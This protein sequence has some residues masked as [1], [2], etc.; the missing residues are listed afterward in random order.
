MPEQLTTYA[1]KRAEKAE[2]LN[3]FSGFKLLHVRK[4]IKL[5]LGQIGRGDIF[6]EYT[7]HDISHIDS[8][9]NSLEWLIPNE[10]KE[11]MSST[12]WLLIVLSVY[13]H[14]MG[15]LVTKQEYE[16][17]HNSA[18]TAF[19]NKMLTDEFN[20][21]FINK[22][23]LLEDEKKEKFLF[24]EFVRKTHAERIKY[25]IISEYNPN[26]VADVQIISELKN[27]LSNLDPMFRRDLG[28]VCES[29]HLSDLE[30]FDKYKI[31]QPYG[32]SKEEE[33]NLHYAALVL[34]TADLLN[35]TSDR[36]PTIE[37]NLISPSDPLSQEEWCKQKAV[38]SVR[39][40]KVVVESEST[41]KKEIDTIEVHAYFEKSEGFFAL[42][43]YL[44]Y[45]KDQLTKSFNLN[46]IAKLK[47]GNLFEFPW[48]KICD[49]NIETVNF[50]KRQFEFSLDQNRIL[51]LLVG[52][53]LYNDSSVVLRE[54]SQ[55][56]L[57]AVKL[58]KYI[59]DIESKQFSPKID[60]HWDENKRELSFLDNGTG[61]TLEVIENHLLK[62]GSSRYHDESFIKKYP[63]FSSISRF[64][65][66]LL[67]CFLIANDLDIITKS[68]ENEKAIKICIRKVHGKYL[69]Q[70]LTSNEIHESIKEHGTE[71][72]L[73]L[74][75]DIDLSKI[76]NELNKWIVFPNCDF[77][78]SLNDNKYTIGYK[79]PKDLLISILEEKG[80][81]LD[82]QNIKVEEASRDGVTLAYALRYI[83]YF[84]EWTYLEYHQRDD[85]EM[86]SLT[87]TCIEGVRVDFNTPGFKGKK[88]VSIANST[89]KNAPKTNVA[90][91]NIENTT[92]R[93]K[94]IQIIYD[95][96]LL[97]IQ[98]QI[99]SLYKSKNFSKSWAVHEANYL[100]EQFI[101]SSR[102]FGNEKE[103]ELEDESIFLIAS[104]ML[105][106]I[107]VE[108]KSS[109]NIINVQEIIKLKHFWTVDSSLFNSADS[110][111]KEIP[112]SNMSSLELINTL[113]SDGQSKVDHIDRLFC[114]FS[115]GGV[116]KR[117]VIEK[118]QVDKI[119][120]FQEQRRVDLRWVETDEKI[121]EV[122]L[123]NDRNSEGVKWYLQVK[124][125]EIE[126]ID[127]EIA[128]GS[129]N[130][131]FILKGS[132]LNTYLLSLINRLNIK[133]VRE[134]GIAFE[135]IV[136]FI[137][138]FFQQESV[139][140]SK[141]DEYLEYEFQNSN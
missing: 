71:I 26:Q 139:D 133:E 121:W 2:N 17:R 123:A 19:K 90:R 77:T 112:S 97:Q 83:P 98:T 102:Y 99:E 48:K 141:I 137:N 49:E 140:Q 15:M 64:G 75:S 57:D 62:V 101:S 36:T 31:S 51:D 128:V 81:S 56:S 92:E 85:N 66:G 100:L 67:T 44:N 78:L 103:I 6:E 8:M 25:W 104:N 94:L 23:N 7:K 5:I 13:F 29:H 118:F 37:F 52:H 20:P 120:T 9:L 111:L 40:E 10:T 131:F 107:L 68:T 125:I 138:R 59:C 21:D 50:E 80:Y 4:Q 96:Y 70:Y 132:K 30:D 76:K 16:N 42:I 69:L 108:E 11:I 106:C 72:K 110:L 24:Q 122:I 115:N 74:R 41:N 60:I 113:F 3:P 114:N 61:M 63:D 135:K 86:D 130:G 82:K 34:R 95:L 35:I 88:I 93:N 117:N 28:I 47:H 119:I 105:K 14:D 39:P 109:K 116:I 32:N 38:K 124:D 54:L 91:S 33:A 46:S 129:R 79:T 18:F 126:N 58:Q 134:D 53:T 65:I 22:V 12:D 84:N 43:S 27:L 73:Y 127:D 45:A 1:E 55:N 87:G 136:I 89:G